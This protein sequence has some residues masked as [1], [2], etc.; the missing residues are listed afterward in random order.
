MSKDLENGKRIAGILMSDDMSAVNRQIQESL[1]GALR[2][3][4]MGCFVGKFMRRRKYG[5]CTYVSVA[6]SHREVY[7]TSK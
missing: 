3:D 7:E 6:I 1:E 4:P 2:Q 5:T